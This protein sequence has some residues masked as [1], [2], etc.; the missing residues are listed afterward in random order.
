MKIVHATFDGEHV[1]LPDDAKPSHPMDVVVV[2]QD[3]TDNERAGL[4]RA[5]VPALTQA[6]NNAEDSVYDEL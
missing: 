6:W 5:S 1:I 4:Q 2:L 3:D